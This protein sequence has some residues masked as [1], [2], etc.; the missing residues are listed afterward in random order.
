MTPPP[1]LAHGVDLV[2]IARIE[3]L[4]ERH[5]ERFLERVFT[6][7]ERAYANASKRPA[8]HL[9]ARFAAKEAALKAL[10][11]GLRYGIFWTDVAVHTGPEGAPTLHLSGKAADFARHR[12]LDGW[13]VSLSHAG[14]FAMASVIAQVRPSKPTP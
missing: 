13:V 6:A 1:P 11:T 5:G 3:Q 7:D 14:G 10:G 8:Q 9:A 4:L 12:D 2:E